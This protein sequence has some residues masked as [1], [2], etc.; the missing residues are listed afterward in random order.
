[1]DR[2]LADNRKPSYATNRCL[3]SPLS[4]LIHTD[5][6]YTRLSNH[7]NRKQTRSSPKLRDLMR[8]L[9]LA[10]SCGLENHTSKTLV[11]FHYDAVSYSQNFDDGFNFR[12]DD[13]RAFPDLPSPHH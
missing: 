6:E 11:T 7:N 8:R 13:P 3:S 9:L 1:M 10:R 12:D 2:D 4:C 5:T